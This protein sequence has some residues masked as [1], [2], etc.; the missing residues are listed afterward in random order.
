MTNFQKK[1]LITI[2]YI[3]TVCY[4]HAAVVD[5]QL[6]SRYL[7]ENS[8]FINFLNT[9]LSNFGD[10]TQKDKLIQATNFEFKAQV[11]QLQGNYE[12]CYKELR[13]SQQILKPLFREV[14]T[15]LYI[16][17]ATKI[18]DS[19]SPLIIN[20]SNVLAKKYVSYAYKHIRLANI[21]V[22]M[23]HGLDE[24]LYSLKI[25]YFIEGITSIRKAKKYILLALIENAKPFAEKP[26]AYEQTYEDA[27]KA[28]E[29]PIPKTPPYEEVQKD[30][31]DLTLR[32]LIKKEISEQYDLLLHHNDN[33]MIIDPKKKSIVVEEIINN[34]LKVDSRAVPLEVSEANND[35]NP[36][37]TNEVGNNQDTPTSTPATEIPKDNP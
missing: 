2:L 32:N 36:L 16:E 28:K 25:K 17:D 37:K 1:I 6:T 8:Y 24:Q 4:S 3:A 20:K 14:L 30:L 23:G 22:D 19:T 29:Y 26:E 10:D 27:K 35:N 5:V 13:N 21:S 7:K 15:K 18:L 33:Y 9:A 31:K 11:F 12:Q 34:K